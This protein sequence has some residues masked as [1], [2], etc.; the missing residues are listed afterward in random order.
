[1]KDGRIVGA[2][3]VEIELEKW[4]ERLPPLKAW[5][6]G[7]KYLFCDVTDAQLA[8]AKQIANAVPAYGWND[9]YLG[10]LEVI[11]F[12]KARS[13]TVI[14]LEQRALQHSR[15]RPKIPNV[16]D[17]FDIPCV[18]LDGFLRAEGFAP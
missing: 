7:H 13:L 6:D 1:M 16:A 11:T 10:D 2:R 3:R 8:A 15:Q 5:L 14:S 18:N 12:A 4:E 17:E 9:N